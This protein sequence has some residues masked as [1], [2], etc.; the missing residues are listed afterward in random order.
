MKKV[1]MLCLAMLLIFSSTVVN[2]AQNEEKAIESFYKENGL[3]IVS[4]VPEGVVPLKVES[5]D[6]LK[7]VTNSY[8]NVFTAQSNQNEIEFE[9]I[10]ITAPDLLLSK[11][12]ILSSYPTYYY[13]HKATVYDLGILGGKIVSEVGYWV[14]GSMPPVFTKDYH[15]VYKSGISYNCE[16]NYNEQSAIVSSDRSHIDVRVRGTIEVY[17]EFH[18]ELILQTYRFDKQYTIGY[19]S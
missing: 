1:S 11:Y 8:K 6:E 12:D 17:V 2:F 7:D 9:R 15:D 18:G 10:Q 3:R 13:V 16:V 5:F 4:E 14:V 19:V